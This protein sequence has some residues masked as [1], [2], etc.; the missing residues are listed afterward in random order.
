MLLK[1][2]GYSF[3][4]V[5]PDVEES[6]CSRCV[7]DTVMINAKLKNEWT[8][9]EY[10][11]SAVISADT[12]I[13]F[14]GHLIGKP[15]DLHNAREQLRMLSN[16]S[17]IVY[18]GI[19]FAYPGRPLYTDVRKSEVTFLPLTDKMIDKYFSLVNPLDKAG[20]YDIGSYGSLI[21]K[22]Y[23]G[24]LSNIIG[25]PMEVINPLLEKYGYRT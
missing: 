3:I 24:S 23:T 14:Q 20:S 15:L 10:S 18:T 25:L 19:A 6:N 16:S 13:E 2:H 1:E 5:T 21:V 17:H 7:E 9:T 4:C 22:S 8:V 11:H 12:A